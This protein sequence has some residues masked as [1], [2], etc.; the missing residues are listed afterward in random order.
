MVPGKVKEMETGGVLAGGSKGGG[1]FRMGANQAWCRFRISEECRGVLLLN[2]TAAAT[3]CC[4]CLPRVLL[5]MFFL[6]FVIRVK[7]LY[8]KQSKTKKTNDS[9]ILVSLF[10]LL[11]FLV[12]Y[13]VP[14]RPSCSCCMRPGFDCN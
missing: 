10:T 1:G 9:E 13:K 7:T 3:Y 2:L 6:F 11:S 5:G 4:C 12:L 14:S 8:A